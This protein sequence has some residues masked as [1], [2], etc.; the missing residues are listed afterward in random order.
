MNFR[1]VC[2]LAVLVVYP[3]VHAVDYAEYDR[4]SELIIT[5]AG[6]ASR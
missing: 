6:T 4:L 5:H 2:W 1:A 3:N